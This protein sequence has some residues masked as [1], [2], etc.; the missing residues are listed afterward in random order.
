MQSI[1]SNKNK[2]IKKKD[3]HELKTDE[4]SKLHN[5]SV[6]NENKSVRINSEYDDCCFVRSIN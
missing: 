4:S 3:N 5:I 2:H 6:F 1:D